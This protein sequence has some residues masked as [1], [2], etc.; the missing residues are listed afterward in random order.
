MLENRISADLMSNGHRLPPS[1]APARNAITTLH[2]STDIVVEDLACPAPCKE[3][4]AV[5]LT[6]RFHLVLPLSGSFRYL[7]ASKSVLAGVNQILLIPPQREYR[8]T[9]P[10]EGDRSMVVFPSPAIVEQL[11]YRGGKGVADTEARS[12]SPT[13]R[14]RALALRSAARNG[15]HPLA[16]DEL[17]IGFCEAA[18][19]SEKIDAPSPLGGRG[20]TLATAKEYLHA[21]YRGPITLADVAAAVGVSPI[22]LTQLFKRSLGMSLHQYVIALRLNEAFF[23]LGDAPDIT[24][25]ALDFGFSSHSHFTAVFRSRFGATPSSIRRSHL[26]DAGPSPRVFPERPLC[27]ARGGRP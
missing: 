24:G 26:P 25:L 13:L 3:A 8:V 7:E 17:S 11:G 15:A 18:F 14:M 10:V 5:G 2:R 27:S 6:H 22:Y 1:K 20:A 12:V 21:H 19:G 4:G 9:H 23:E 16:L